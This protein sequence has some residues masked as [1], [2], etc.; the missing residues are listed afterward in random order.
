VR[1]QR[2]DAGAPHRDLAR[3]LHGEK[4]PAAAF[5]TSSSVFARI[6]SD[7]IWH[8]YFMENSFF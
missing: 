4:L 8:P 5:F 2:F 6:N 7:L 1:R 3:P